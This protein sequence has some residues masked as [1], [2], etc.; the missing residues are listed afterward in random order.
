MVVL[1]KK[2]KKMPRNMKNTDASV[3]LDLLEITVSSKVQLGG[4]GRAQSGDS[5]K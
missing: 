2:L 5:L 1:A 4:G 3:Q